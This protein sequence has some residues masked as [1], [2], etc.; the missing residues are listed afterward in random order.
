MLVSM[1]KTGKTKSIFKCDR[2][3]VVIETG[4]DERYRMSINKTSKHKTIKGYDLC[5][6]CCLTI[7]KIIEKGVKKEDG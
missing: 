4:V 2:C 5:K 6:R 1:D 3:G 7:C